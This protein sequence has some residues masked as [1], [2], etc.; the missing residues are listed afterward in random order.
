MRI[1]D[2]SSDVCSSDLLALESLDL[3]LDAAEALVAFVGGA[4]DAGHRANDRAV[5]GVDLLQRI[6]NL[7]HC[8]AH[9]RRLH[10]EVEQVAAAVLGSLRQIGQRCL[11]GLLVALTADL[12]ETFHLLLAHRGVV[13]VEDLDRLILSGTVPDRKSTRL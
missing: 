6:R 9:P 13:D 2:W 8:R 4:V 1:S 11:D 10:C 3:A 5:A 12:L 7:S